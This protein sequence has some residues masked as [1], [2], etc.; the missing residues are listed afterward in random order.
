MTPDSYPIQDRYRLARERNARRRLEARA[1]PGLPIDGDA[2]ETRLPVASVGSVMEGIMTA[3]MTEKSPFFDQVCD[4]WK[5][6]F[7][8]V[9]ATPGRWQGGKLFV[10]VRSSAQLFALRPRLAKMRRALAALPTAPKRFSVHLE[11]H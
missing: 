7:P 1:T 8:D 6:L 4:E 9:A 2:V 5:T 11:I 10:Y 3:L